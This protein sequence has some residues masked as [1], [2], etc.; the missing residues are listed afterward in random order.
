MNKHLQ[1]IAIIAIAMAWCGSLSAGIRKVSRINSTTIE[2]TDDKGVTTTIDF[3]G[4]NIFRLFQDPKGGIVRDPVAEPPA[5]ILVDNPRRK[6]TDW[7]RQVDASGDKISI[8]TE[9]IT[10]YIDPNT[11]FIS[12]KDNRTG[13]IAFRQTGAFEYNDR[14]VSFTLANQKDEYFYGGGVQNGR[15]SHRGT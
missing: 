6:I 12:V 2:L 1:R 9:A 3:Y 13:K 5:K 4:P 7:P 8:A 10:L 14:G 15:F 11:M